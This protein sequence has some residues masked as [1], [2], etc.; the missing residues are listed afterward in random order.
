MPG[1]ANDRVEPTGTSPATRVCLVTLYLSES[2]GVRQLSALLK[3]RGHECSLIFFKEFRW[4]EFHLVTPREEELLLELLRDLQPARTP[5]A[6][7][8]IP[9]APR[10]P[11]H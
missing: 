3:A 1:Q 9:R 2:L 4:G 5:L 11:V 10:L 7:C 8:V 6:L